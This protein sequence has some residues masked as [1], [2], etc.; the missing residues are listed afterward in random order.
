MR[1]RGL[2]PGERH[3][4]CLA[5]LEPSVPCCEMGQLCLR[6][7]AQHGFRAQGRRPRKANGVATWGDIKWKVILKTATRLQARKADLAA[8][9]TRGL[10][11]VGWWWESLDDKVRQGRGCAFVRSVFQDTGSVSQ[12]ELKSNW[13]TLSHKKSW[14]FPQLLA[15][16]QLRQWTREK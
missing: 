8:A 16:S 10:T 12:R 13:S 4:D 11:R 9:L 5:A 2:P 14:L 15:C 3:G 7:K 6:N 1:Y